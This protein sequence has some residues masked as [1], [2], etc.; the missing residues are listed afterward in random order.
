M[1]KKNMKW[2][3]ALGDALSMATSFAA[4]VGFGWWVGT[5]LDTHFHTAPYLMLVMIL[6]GVATGLKIIYDMAFGKKGFTHLSDTEDE[7]EG[8]K[9]YGPS[10][11]AI[12]AI[13]EAK[14]MLAGLEAEK[15]KPAE[16]EQ[17]DE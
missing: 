10:K 5:K 3:R 11:E 17:Q 6:V 13:N 12:D 4:A 15:T 14:R 8:R 9:R 2:S 1:A 16:E 7:E